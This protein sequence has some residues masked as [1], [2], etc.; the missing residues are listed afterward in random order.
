MLVVAVCCCLLHC[1]LCVFVDVFGVVARHWLLFVAVCYSWCW[2]R[3][4]VCC[5]LLDVVVC[6]CVLLFAVLLLMS[7]V[8]CFLFVVCCCELLPFAVRCCW[9]CYG[10]LSLSFVMVCCC[11]CLS[12]A[13]VRCC[14]LLLLVGAIGNC[15]R[16]CG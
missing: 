13:D 7:I 15:C 8:S 11:W 9:R 4:V 3:S 12:F 10:W 2:L 6:Y 1:R 5:L 16:F 14:C